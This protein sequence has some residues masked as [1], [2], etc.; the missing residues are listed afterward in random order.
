MY[1]EQLPS[2]VLLKRCNSFLLCGSYRPSLVL[3]PLVLFPNT[4]QWLGELASS[5]DIRDRLENPP[6]AA[7]PDPFPCEMRATG[8]VN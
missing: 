3:H 1:R 6:F 2:V 5:I 7:E 8:S 4:H